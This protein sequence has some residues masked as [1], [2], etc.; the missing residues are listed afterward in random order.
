MESRKR[1]NIT[2]SVARVFAIISVISAHTNLGSP[3]WAAKMINALGSIGVVIFI[4]LSGYFYRPEKYPSI[5]MMLSE[6]AKTIG[7]PWIVMG[8]LSYISGAIVSDGFSIAR[9]AEYLIGKGSFL[10]YLPVLIICYIIFYKQNSIAYL[11]SGVVTVIS[12]YATAF[13]QLDG[14]IETLHITHYLN[15]LNWVGYFGLG[16]YLRS[17]NTDK[18]YSFISKSMGYSVP[19]FIVCYICICVFRIKSGYF[20]Y[21]GMP[22][23]LLGALAAI[24]MSTLNWLDKK[25]IHTVSNMTF[26]I[27]F[28]HMAMIGLVDIVFK[29]NIFTKLLA[30][31]IVLFF[32]AVLLY[33]GYLCAKHIKLEKLYCTLTGMRMNRNIQSH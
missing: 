9:W 22:Y 20:S 19:L 6:K 11:I 21:I 2:F 32:S 29:I 33:T 31:L 3:E 16:C 30:P 23:Q 8:S 5:L 14:V 25:L 18:L 12:V 13:G 10:Y 27:Y 24:G 15:V 26:A 4:I 1:I 28:V 7:I 17:L